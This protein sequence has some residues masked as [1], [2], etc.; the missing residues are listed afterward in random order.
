MFAYPLIGSIP[1]SA[2]ATEHVMQVLEPIWNS[3]RETASRLRGRIE[4]ILDWARVSGFRKG[5]NPARWRDHLRHLLSN[6]KKPVRHYPSLAYG[7]LATF[8]SVLQRQ[9]GVAAC[10][11]EFTILTAARTSETT[12]MRFSEIDWTDKVWTIPPSA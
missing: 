9:A 2:L 1:T 4:K 7:Q 10:A 6:Q 3:K 8:C 11:L 5:E 12:G